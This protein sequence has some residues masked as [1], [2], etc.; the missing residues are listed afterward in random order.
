M[1]SSPLLQPARVSSRLRTDWARVWSGGSMVT[2]CSKHRKLLAVLFDLVRCRRRRPEGQRGN[3]RRA[4][5]VR[6]RFGVLVDLGGFRI[7]YGGNHP[8]VR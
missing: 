4:Q 6:E 3:V 1:N 5:R 8:V 7:R 2:M